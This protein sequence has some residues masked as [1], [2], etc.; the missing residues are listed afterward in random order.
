M[1]GGAWSLV[2]VWLR[3]SPIHSAIAFLTFTYCGVH[4]ICSCQD[5]IKKTD[6]RLIFVFL[7][8]RS[9]KKTRSLSA[10]YIGKKGSAQGCERAVAQ[11]AEGEFRA[12]THGGEHTIFVVANCT[13][14]FSFLSPPSHFFGCLFVGFWVFFFRGVG[15]SKI[16]MPLEKQ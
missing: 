4:S 11:H 2:W 8:W 7:A 1:G 13:S 6:N 10:V 16:S 3:V 5:L 15:V 9:H 14:H 12:A